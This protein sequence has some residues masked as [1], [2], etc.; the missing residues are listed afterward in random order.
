MLM[1]FNA[2]CARGFDGQVFL[3]KIISW[4]KLLQFSWVNCYINGISNALCA[5]GFDGQVF[6]VQIIPWGY[7]C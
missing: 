1:G 6:L 4:G 2:L 5:K 7:S 3:V